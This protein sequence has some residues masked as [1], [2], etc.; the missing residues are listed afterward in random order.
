MNQGDLGPR[1]GRRAEWLAAA[2]LSLAG[3]IT[4][5]TR[6]NAQPIPVNP[7]PQGSPIPRVQPRAAPSVQPG[8][9]VPPPSAPPSEVP[10]RPVR[11]TGVGVEGVTAYPK[12]EIEQLTTGLVLSLIHI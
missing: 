4:L 7:V 11:V 1:S 9:V 8:T 6:G 5:T 2:L 10:N 12:G 3:S